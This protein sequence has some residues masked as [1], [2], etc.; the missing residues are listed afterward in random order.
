MN[1]VQHQMK[2]GAS[3]FNRYHFREY[4]DVCHTR[5]SLFMQLSTNSA[6]KDPLL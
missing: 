2:P 3:L 5:M 1:N 6:I 4:N